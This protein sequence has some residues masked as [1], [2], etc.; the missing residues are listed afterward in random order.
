MTGV[1]IQE[2]EHNSVLDAQCAMRIYTMFRKEWET[3][4]NSK[5]SKSGKSAKIQN[6]EILLN[7]TNPNDV[8]V[9]TGNNKHKRYVVNKIKRR[10]KF[11]NKK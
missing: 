3:E 5:F 9:K 6:Q 11:L 4:I 1:T 2:G 7:Y 10:N 8:N